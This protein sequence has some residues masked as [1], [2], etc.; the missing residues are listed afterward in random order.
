M[1]YESTGHDLRDRI[2]ALIPDNPI[3]LEA[4]FSPWDLSSIKGFYCEDI[5]P[6]LAQAGWALKAA[7][8]YW[9]NNLEATHRGEMKME[10]SFR[11]IEFNPRRN[12]RGVEA[13]RVEVNYDGDI[14]WLWM[15]KEDVQANIDEFGECEGLRTALDAYNN[16][17]RNEND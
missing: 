12:A 3:I 5:G 2:V 14:G 7:R 10:I 1:D 4:V 17:G 13:A 8:N 16:T 11:F 9:A 6:T 15:S